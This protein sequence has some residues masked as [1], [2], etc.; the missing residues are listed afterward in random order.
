MTSRRRPC[1][2]A[3]SYVWSRIENLDDGVGP[4]QPRPHGARA[5]HARLER[6]EVEAPIKGVRPQ[7]FGGNE[8]GGILDP[9]DAPDHSLFV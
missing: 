5:E 2:G 6:R 3:H 1:I 8:I 7:P 4:I 9:A